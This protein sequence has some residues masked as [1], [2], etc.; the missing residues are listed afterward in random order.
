MSPRRES[1]E[2]TSAKPCYIRLPAG[3]EDKRQKHQNNEPSFPSSRQKLTQSNLVKEIWCSLQPETSA[4]PY[5]PVISPPILV[6][7]FWTT[8][9]CLLAETERKYILDYPFNPVEDVRIFFPKERRYSWIG[10]RLRFFHGIRMFALDM[11]YKVLPTPTFCSLFPQW[12]FHVF[13]PR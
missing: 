1:E 13:S 11:I 7:V 3:C 8:E 6:Q 4:C 10:W 2:Q 5:I 12:H 9:H